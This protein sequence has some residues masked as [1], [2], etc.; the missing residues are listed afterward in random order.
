MWQAYRNPTTG[1]M[2]PQLVEAAGSWPQPTDAGGVFRFASNETPQDINEFNTTIEAM[3]K[4]QLHVT[5][6]ICTHV[7]RLKWC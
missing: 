3:L 4:G 1:E 5:V 2:D 6:Q 7:S